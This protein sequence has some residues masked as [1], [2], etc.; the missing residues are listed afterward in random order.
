MD[1][2]WVGLG[3]GLGAMLRYGLTLGIKAIWPGT[4]PWA[5]L[6]VNLSGT[7][8]LGFLLGWQVNQPVSLF[9]GTG[10]LGGY[11]TFSTFNTELWTLFHS[12]YYWLFV[13]YALIS[14]GGGILL[15]YVGLLIGQK[16]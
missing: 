11:T 14:Y 3:A 8:L 4:F 5:T 9:L 10:L 6:A 15:A 12:R 1:Y 16:I 13:Y 7:L 2:F